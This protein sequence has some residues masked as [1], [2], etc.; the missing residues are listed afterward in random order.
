MS[1]RSLLLLLAFVG[2]L[3]VVAAI[4]G[5]AQ[6]AAAATALIVGVPLALLAHGLRD[7]M[8]SYGVSP[9]EFGPSQPP[10]LPIARRAAE[11]RP[12]ASRRVPAATTAVRSAVAAGA[13]TGG[14]R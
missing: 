14:T 2:T 8:A 5:W 11:P 10:H 4:L 6:V 7:A 3:D 13:E 9:S 1:L 12:A